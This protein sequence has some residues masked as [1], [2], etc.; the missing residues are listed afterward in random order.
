MDIIDIMGNSSIKVNA[1][2]KNRKESI[3]ENFLQDFDQLRTAI[4]ETFSIDSSTPIVIQLDETY[5]STKHKWPPKLKK[6]EVDLKIWNQIENSVQDSIN[7]LN[8]KKHLFKVQN[9]EG[10]IK[11]LGLFL[12][13]DVCLI[14]KKLVDDDISMIRENSIVFF[15]QLSIHD[16]KAVETEFKLKDSLCIELLGDL[17]C[18]QN[19]ILIHL[20]THNKNWRITIPNNTIRIRGHV[21]YFNKSTQM[22]S[23]EKTKYESINRSGPFR[24]S[25]ANDNW[26]PGAIFVSENSEVVGIYIGGV[27]K[28]FIPVKDI[29]YQLSS[30][31][32]SAIKER[33][34]RVRDMIFNVGG[35]ELAIPE[36]SSILLNIRPFD[37]PHVEI[38]N[39]LSKLF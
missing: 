33:D 23:S 19:F 37:I 3:S 7:T 14:P 24:L 38:V 28:L 27:G 17:I 16:Q 35:V 13:P 11:G 31:L 32:S 8:F 9:P 39:P 12:S 26:L 22:L 15:D 10:K 21:I 29:F 25:Y 1:S 5:H 4:K 34:N 36:I 20:N 2:Y 18:D 6:N 30:K